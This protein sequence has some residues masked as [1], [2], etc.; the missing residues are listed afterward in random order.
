VILPQLTLTGNWWKLRRQISTCLTLDNYYTYNPNLWRIKMTLKGRIEAL[1]AKHKELEKKIHEYDSSV[2]SE[3]DE[4]I[5]QLKKEKLKM[6]DEITALKEE[7][8]Q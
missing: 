4:I 2:D 5:N 7:E 1:E 6:K 8:N 3:H